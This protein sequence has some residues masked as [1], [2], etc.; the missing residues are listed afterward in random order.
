MQ[1]KK[2]TTERVNYPSRRE[3]NPL[4]LTIALTLSASVHAQTDGDIE[5]PSNI[6]GGKSE[7]LSSIDTNESDKFPTI[8]DRQVV[9]LGEM[10]I[11]E[12]DVFSDE[13]CSSSLNEQNEST[14]IKLN[15]SNILKVKRL[16]G[17]MAR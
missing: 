17:K 2:A 11:E 12:R 8:D 14:L 16:M 13:N 4:L 6:E 9:I 15:Q 3:F 5:I 1:L 7:Y 10:N